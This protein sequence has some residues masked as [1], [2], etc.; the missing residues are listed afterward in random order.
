V[1]RGAGLDVGTPDALGA[2]DVPREAA[3]E[4]AAVNAGADEAVVALGA[5]LGPARVV[6]GAPPARVLVAGVVGLAVE[7]GMGRRRWKISVRYQ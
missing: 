7:A 5:A 2:V 3:G 6:D 4:E 1:G